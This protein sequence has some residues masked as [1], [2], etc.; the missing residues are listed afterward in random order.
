[1]DD[2]NNENII[3]TKELE[4]WENIDCTGMLS[5]RILCS[6]TGRPPKFIRF[7]CI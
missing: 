3:G 4:S 6:S 1:M 5:F 2:L 7:W